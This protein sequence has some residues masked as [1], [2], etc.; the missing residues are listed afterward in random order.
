MK[1]TDHQQENGDKIISNFKNPDIDIQV[2]KGAAGVGKTTLADYLVQHLPGKS[3][4]TAPTNKAVSVI[5]SKVRAAHEFTHTK[6]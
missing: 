5:K 4:V 3:L 6:K 1:L 2:L